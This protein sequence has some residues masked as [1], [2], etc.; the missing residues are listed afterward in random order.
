MI[1]VLDPIGKGMISLPLVSRTNT[2]VKRPAKCIC[3]VPKEGT[4]L[5]AL[6]PVE[7]NKEIPVLY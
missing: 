2:A 6:P 3:L 7:K 5:W 1:P 4:D